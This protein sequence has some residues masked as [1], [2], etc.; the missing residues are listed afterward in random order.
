METLLLSTDIFLKG[1]LFFGLSG[2]QEV[3]LSH[4]CLCR[5]EASCLCSQP[6]ARPGLANH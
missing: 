5:S 2:G 6:G 3:V 1:V 4:V